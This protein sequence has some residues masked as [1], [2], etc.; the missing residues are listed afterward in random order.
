MLQDL[1]KTLRV[2]HTK[3]SLARTLKQMLCQVVGLH[4]ERLNNNVW[5]SQTKIGVHTIFDGQMSTEWAREQD[6]YL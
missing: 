6:E 5:A 2:I 4:H 3:P 1:D